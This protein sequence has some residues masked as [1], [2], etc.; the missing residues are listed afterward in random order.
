MLH[1]VLNESYITFYEHQWLMGTQGCDHE[2]LQEPPHDTQ[3]AEIQYFSRNEHA[4]CAL[5][6]LLTDK[7][8]SSL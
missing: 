1:H 7:N 5:C 3:G 4:F 2:E 6:K 8:G